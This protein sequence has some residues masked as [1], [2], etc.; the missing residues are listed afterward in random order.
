MDGFYT[1]HWILTTLLALPVI[2]SLAV[3]AVPEVR[4]RA[5][6]LGVSLLELAL[7]LPL[8]WT[9]SPTGVCR[10]PGVLGPLS[11]G[12]KLVPLSNCVAIPWVPDWGIFYRVGL[13]GL[14]LVLVLLTVVL[15]PL[16]VLGSWTY[17][18]HRQRTF[19]AMLLLLTT[20]V[21]GVFVSFDLF[22]FYVFWEMMLIPMYFLIGI[23]GGE[24]RIYAAVKFFLYTTFGSLLMLVAILYLVHRAWRA[25]GILSFHYFDL[26]QTPLTLEQQLW[27]FAAFG[28]AFAIKVPI[29]P[30]HTWLPA[31]HWQA[32]TA[33][34]V[35]LAG[36]LLKMG[37]YG[38]LRFALPYFPDA[39]THPAVVTLLL[40][41]GVVGVI[42][43]AWVAAVQED[44]KRLVAYTSVAHL[45]YAVVGLFALTT[46]SVQG[47]IVLMLAHGLSTP[48]LFFLLGMLYERR[49]TYRI[50]DYGGLASTVPLWSTALVVAALASV[51]LPGTSGFVSEFLVILGSVKTHPWIGILTATGAVWAVFYMLPMVQRMIFG[52]VDNEANRRIPDLRLR[53]LAVLTPL[54]LGILWLGIYPR[55]VLERTEPAVQTILEM[56]GRSRVTSSPLAG[57]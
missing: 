9:V 22:L 16:M 40:V 36:V 29:V 32:P 19:Y 46:E 6:A 49:H 37:V 11:W 10:V 35:V 20:G 17:I 44:A 28:L 12:P 48:M 33:G 18:Q 15:L 14:S 31:A 53:E 13:D 23:W 55:P 42:Y 34:S 8:F 57:R 41:L 45:G 56:A 54:V 43:G 2:G 24:R 5:V 21:I 3:L 27:L 39:A 38:F 25:T 1:S 47:A 26:L 7:A 30:F 51:G 52:R 50:A 4:A